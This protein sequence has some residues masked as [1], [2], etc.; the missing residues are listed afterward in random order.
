MTPS[1]RLACPHCHSVNRI[2]GGKD[3]AAGRC[4]RC[5]N[6]LFAGT[7]VVL[8]ADSFQRHAGSDLPLAVDFWAP[9]CAPC[10]A[11]APAFEQAA[12]HLEPRARFGKVNT[13]DEQALAGRFAIRGIPTIIIFRGGREAARQSGAMD[14][15]A[16]VRWL[17][18]H[19]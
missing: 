12:A 10:R 9:W 17:E 7:P 19:L 13:D 5:R 11:M 15:G 2:P 18:A 4:G 8:T 1:R 6:T 14:F 16:L 3:P